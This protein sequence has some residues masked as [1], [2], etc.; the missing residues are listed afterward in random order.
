[1]APTYTANSREMAVSGSILK[2][3]GRVRATDMV[4]VIPG[5]APKNV[6][7]ETPAKTARIFFKV[8][9]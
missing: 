7:M 4:M 6:P 9:K 1:M 3:N 2:V 5:T 8:K